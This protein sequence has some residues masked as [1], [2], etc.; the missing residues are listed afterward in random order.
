MNIQGKVVNVLQPQTGSGKNGEWVKSTYIVETPGQYPK[1]VAVT[2][3]GSTLPV[4]KEGQEVDCQIDVESREYNGK[5]FTEVKCFK[6]DFIGGAPAKSGKPKEAAKSEP[7]I[8]LASGTDDFIGSAPD[9]PE[10]E[11]PF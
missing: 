10:S 9:G 2:I 8:P 5:W 7:A 4:L 11:L 1:K 6:V 3:W